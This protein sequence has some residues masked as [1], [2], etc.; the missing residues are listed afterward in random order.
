MFYVMKNNE[1]VAWICV[2][3]NL[4]IVTRKKDDS[5][6]ES[7]NDQFQW[8]YINDGNKHIPLKTPTPLNNDL[9]ICLT[10]YLMA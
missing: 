4:Y 3:T 2:D 9:K 6:W 10:D 5:G 1:I 7:Y 8:K